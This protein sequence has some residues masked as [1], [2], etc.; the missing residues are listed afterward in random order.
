MFEF[1]EN[2]L[3][4][5][6]LPNSEV[7]SCSNYCYED[8]SSYTT[9]LSFSS[10]FP[11]D[12]GK[13]NS[14]NNSISSITSNT[15][16]NPTTSTNTITNTNNNLSL[17]YDPQ[18]DSDNNDI[19]ASINFLTAPTFSIPPI[20]TNQ[21]DQFDMSTMQT[22]I[23]LADVVNGLS[24]YPPDLTVPMTGLP[25]PLVFEDD[26]LSSLP[27]YGNLDPSSPSCSL[28]DPTMGP[29]LSGAL[30]SALSADA[31]GIYSGSLLMGSELQPH[32]LE[33]QGENLGVYCSDSV[34]CYSSGDMQQVTVKE[35]DEM[36]DSSDIFAHIS[37]VNSFKCN[38][39]LQSWI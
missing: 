8:N 7:S 16:N 39:P 26:C 36:V 10:S 9:I 5:D 31:S 11:S 32:E 28:I 21:E 1:C 18:D 24:P 30:S 4:S 6:N 23:P 17:L 27:T 15:N 35:E 34:Q 33:F 19:S 29:Y 25:L 12:V 14:N 37:G 13:F 2:E 20:I 38:Y 22:Q 3:F